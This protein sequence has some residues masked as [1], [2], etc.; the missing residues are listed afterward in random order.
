[1]NIAAPV[2]SAPEMSDGTF[3]GYVA[4]LA[5]S[6]LLCVIVA[7]VVQQSVGMRVLNALIGLAFLGY[8]FY[9]F[10]IFD[11]GTVRIF[12]YAFIVPILLIVQAIRGRKAQPAE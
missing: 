6:G 2:L 1:M 11:G 12:L 7:A 3:L 5:I 9:L 8:A 4:A 10:F